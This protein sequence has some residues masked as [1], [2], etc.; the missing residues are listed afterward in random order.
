MNRSPL[1]PPPRRG[2]GPGVRGKCYEYPLTP[3]L[4]P[5]AEERE[6]IVNHLPSA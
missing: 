4:S 6:N 3:T 5:E 1:S 2:E